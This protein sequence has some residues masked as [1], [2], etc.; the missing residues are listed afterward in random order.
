VKKPS[1]T[2]WGGALGPK[3]FSHVV[4]LKCRTGF[5]S[6]N[7][8]SNRTAITAYVVISF[9]IVFGVLVLTRL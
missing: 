9:V 4:C 8:K 7:G 3:L 2:W 6:K 1:F 5:N